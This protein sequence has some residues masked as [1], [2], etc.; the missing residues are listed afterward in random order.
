MT[1][2]DLDG[3]KEA[4]A[5][6]SD[7]YQQPKVLNPESIGGSLLQ[8]MPTPTG[9]R[10]LILPYR[11]KGKT[12]SGLYLP[13]QIVEQQQ[14]STQV[15]YVLKVGPLA[16]QDEEKFPKGAWCEE[17]D[18]VMFARYAG[19][20]FNI[21]GGEVRIIND[22]E[23][24]GTILDQIELELETEEATEVETEP[25]PQVEAVEAEPD[26]YQKADSATQKRIDRL[27]KK[28]REAE[29]R[30]KEALNYAKQVQN[31]SQQLKGR[32]ANLDDSFVNEFSNRVTS[33]LDQAEKE[34]ARAMEIGDTQAAV[35]A[36]RKITA[37]A[38]ENDRAAQAK[39]QQERIVA[40][41][42]QFAQQQQVAPQAQPQEVRRPDRKAEQ[43]AEKNEWF[44]SD[45]AMTYAA[46]GIHKTL[47]EEEQFDPS[48]DDYYN[49]LDR[50]IAEK[51]NVSSNT[52]SKRPV[53][54]VAGVSRQ[55][56]G[57]SSGK[58]VR[59]SPSQV[60]IAKKLGVPLSEYAK[61]VKD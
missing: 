14:V 19:S 17:K 1:K 2:V 3:V 28:M 7:A 12:E 43:W 59:L 22:D 16:Y 9:W 35:E 54:T 5:N 6:L 55:N 30:E 10:I 13:D 58:K 38:I 61:Y 31:E 25:S 39:A 46:F 23:V 20:R 48:S 26:Q 57:R 44:G 29:R 15:G 51:F 50:R 49:E 8:R 33:Q 56:S 37:L 45:D 52:T 41:R 53:Q 24:I 32:M 18:W 47:V 60:A 4:V 40:Q 21:D 11:G 34:L 42:Q 27:T 36:N